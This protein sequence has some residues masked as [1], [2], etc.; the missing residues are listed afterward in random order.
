MK[1]LRITFFLSV[2]A[3]C[4]CDV[5]ISPEEK[6]QSPEAK[7]VQE[8]LPS[9]P[10]IEI[11]LGELQSGNPVLTYLPL[12]ALYS[13]L[14][15]FYDATGVTVSGISLEAGDYYLM[16]EGLANAGGKIFFALLLEESSGIINLTLDGGT[17]SCTTREC[18]NGCNKTIFS[19]TSGKCTCNSDINIGDCHNKLSKMS[20]SYT[21]TSYSG[22]PEISA[23]VTNLHNNAS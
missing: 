11:Q 4:A 16:G 10:I 14:G 12:N 5:S 23:L 17:H 21:N 6:P 7:E 8:V 15:T 22:G 13:E 19:P 1:I 2:F 18:C 3:F 9:N 20:C